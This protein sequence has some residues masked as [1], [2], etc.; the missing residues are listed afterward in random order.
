MTKTLN[1]S[2]EERIERDREQNRIAQTKYRE[3]HGDAINA[4]RR[5]IL[6]ENTKQC[7]IIVEKPVKSVNQLEPVNKPIK[8]E[9]IV[10]K[11]V[12]T[13]NQLETVNKPIKQKDSIDEKEHKIYLIEKSNIRD[14]NGENVYKIGRT[15]QNGL[16]R[17]KD[18]PKK[19]K[20]IIIRSCKNSVAT[21]LKILDLFKQKYKRVD[22]N[23][24]FSGDWFEMVKDINNILDEEYYEEKRLLSI[25]TEENKNVVDIEENCLN[26]LVNNKHD[27]NNFKY[28][29]I[30]EEVSIFAPNFPDT[31][32]IF[33][34]ETEKENYSICKNVFVDCEN[35]FND[36]EKKVIDKFNINNIEDLIRNSCISK[37][38]KQRCLK[39]FS[40]VRERYELMGVEPFNGHD[41]IQLDNYAIVIR[42][43]PNRDIKYCKSLGEKDAVK[44]FTFIGM[45]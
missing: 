36:T 43:L 44:D 3:K 24:Y 41:V 5:V 18:Y 4:R 31:T 34:F 13:V 38:D 12:K 30:T 39:C 22:R 32:K 17:L 11:T 21:E 1:I 23:E 35:N 42:V 26:T 37:H 28:T 40:Y 6:K 29:F 15:A 7:E 14:E 45:A 8:Q 10:E 16:N 2:A 9:I 19:D 33:A 25:K 27:T 20:I